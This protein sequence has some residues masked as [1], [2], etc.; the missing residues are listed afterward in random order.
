M[1]SDSGN[2]FSS[3]AA[4][5]VTKNQEA[6]TVTGTMHVMTLVPSESCLWSTRTLHAVVLGG[7]VITGY[8]GSLPLFLAGK[9]SPC[10]EA[11]VQE[12]LDTNG[13]HTSKDKDAEAGKEVVT[14]DV[15]SLE[16]PLKA[17]RPDTN[18]SYD[19]HDVPLRAAAAAPR[20]QEGTMTREMP[21]PDPTPKAHLAAFGAASFGTSEVDAA[22][23][24]V[25]APTGTDRGSSATGP[26]RAVQRFERGAAHPVGRGDLATLAMR[27]TGDSRLPVVS[28]KKGTIAVAIHEDSKIADASINIP[29]GVKTRGHGRIVDMDDMGKNMA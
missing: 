25:L 27:Q 20:P 2:T 7:D 14:I 10:A 9:S 16:K 19:R 8:S 1:V 22:H 11:M 24:P 18:W 4:I 23:G 21:P 17:A 13:K 5:L 12:K 29:V 15:V 3:T 26:A 28:D 6:G